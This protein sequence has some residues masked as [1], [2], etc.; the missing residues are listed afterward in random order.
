[1]YRFIYLYLKPEEYKIGAVI[2]DRALVSQL[3]FNVILVSSVISMILKA[4][5]VIR[6]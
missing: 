1:M 2:P 3:R 6:A 4:R 5:S